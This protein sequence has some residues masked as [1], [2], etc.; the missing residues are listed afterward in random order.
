MMVVIPE[1]KNIVAMSSPRPTESPDIH[2]GPAS[3]KGTER[4]DPKAVRYCW[5]GWGGEREE[6]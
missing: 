4:V 2:R 6:F 3:T 1:V 5:G